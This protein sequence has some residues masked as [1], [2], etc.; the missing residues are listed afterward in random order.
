M[1]ELISMTPQAK[2]GKTGILAKSKGRAKLTDKHQAKNEKR[3]KG[4][5]CFSPWSLHPHSTACP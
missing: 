5:I 3:T 1:K 2:T 4:F